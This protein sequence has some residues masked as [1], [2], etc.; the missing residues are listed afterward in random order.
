MRRLPSLNKLMAEADVLSIHAPLSEETRGIIGKAALARAKPGM[1]VINTARGPIV[2]LGA[3]HDALKSGR[4][5]GAGI[6]VLEREPADPNHPLIAAWRRRE[7]WLDGRLT[8]SP[9][10]AFY[11][12]ASIA[13]LRAK[14]LETVLGYLEGGPAQNC[15]NAQFLKPKG[16]K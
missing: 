9:H 3:L 7:P 6:D 1:I 14:S 13:D 15:V 4:I 2:D 5:G 16:R 12:P 10:A 8:L 11:S